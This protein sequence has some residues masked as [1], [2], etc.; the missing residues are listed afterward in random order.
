MR[1][2]LLGVRSRLGQP[3]A[4]ARAAEAVLKEWPGQIEKA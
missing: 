1:G 4:S 2:D 3:G